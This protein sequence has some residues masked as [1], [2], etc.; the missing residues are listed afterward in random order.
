MITSQLQVEI[1]MNHHVEAD[2]EHLTGE[3]L[4]RVLTFRSDLTLPC[5][6]TLRTT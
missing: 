2:I 1:V 4:L 3:A 6:L 5:L